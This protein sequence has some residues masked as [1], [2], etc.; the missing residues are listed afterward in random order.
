V[1]WQWRVPGH[2]PT[3]EGADELVGHLL[4][5]ALGVTLD[6]A[7]AEVVLEHGLTGAIQRGLHRAPAAQPVGV[8]DHRQGRQR[9]SRRRRSS[10]TE[11]QPENG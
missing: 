11:Q 4:D 7:G 10:G 3:E 5:P 1:W 8:A 6:H 9:P 2:A